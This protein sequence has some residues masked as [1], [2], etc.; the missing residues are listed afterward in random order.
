MGN[1]LL[2]Y[3]AGPVVDRFRLK[4]IGAMLYLMQNVD[5]QTQRFVAIFRKLKNYSF[6]ES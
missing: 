6:S 5:I 1:R 2:P 3:I 4:K